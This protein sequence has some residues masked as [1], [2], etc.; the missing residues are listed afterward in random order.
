MVQSVSFLGIF[1]LSIAIVLCNCLI[2]FALEKSGLRRWVSALAACGIPLWLAIHGRNA[3]ATPDL[4]GGT[5]D[6]AM[7]QPAIPQ[8]KKWDE[9]YFHEVM[10]KTW[11]TME[12]DSLSVSPA[13]AGSELIVL[14]ETAVP[15]F[16][17]N[18]SAIYAG[19]FRVARK[20]HADVLIGSLD[21]SPGDKPYAEYKF[22]NSAFLFPGDGVDSVAQYSKLKLVPF[23]ERL[24]FDDVFPLL[25][26]VNLGEGDFSPGQGYALWG[27]RVRYSPSICY[28]VIYSDFVREARRGGASVLV[29][30]TNDGWFGNSN[31]PYQHAAIARF[32]AIESGM[33][34]ARCSNTGISVF[35][36]YKGRI[37][38]KTK[39]FEQTVLR[40]KLPLIT[41]DTWYLKHGDTVESWLAWLFPIG[42]LWCVWAG[43]KKRDGLPMESVAPKNQELKKQSR[44]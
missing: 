13:L 2:Y 3:L 32:R 38:G 12:A 1:G 25:N 8:T 37:I 7:V 28:E 23:S 19:F 5:M 17:R 11:R 9:H 40:R 39:L 4:D 24:P 33:P 22:F 42:L 41:R 30:I 44:R 15:D 36:D 10:E 43:W 20:Y 34:I 31:E 21:Y 27:R 6:I 35:Y 29:N 14:P 16:L 26:Y 18:D